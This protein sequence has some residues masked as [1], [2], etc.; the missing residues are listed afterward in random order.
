MGFRFTT[1]L[2]M[3][4]VAGLCLSLPPAGQ[5]AGVDDLLGCSSLQKAIE[6]EDGSVV[7]IGSTDGCYSNLA[8]RGWTFLVA[9]SSDGKLLPSFGSGGLVRLP[10]GTDSLLLGRPNG[11]VIVLSGGALVSYGANG[12]PDASFGNNGQLTRDAIRRV[13][14]GSDHKLYVLWGNTE[15]ILER[16]NL[17]GTV[18]DGF[19]N[20]G[21]LRI[22]RPFDSGVGPAIDVEGR[23]Y[24]IDGHTAIRLLPDGSP[25]PD[26]GSG[27]N[28]EVELDV[29]PAPP[30][31]YFPNLVRKIELDRDGNF[32]V[33][34]TGSYDLYSKPSFAAGLDPSGNPLP[35]LPYLMSTMDIGSVSLYNG[36][37][38]YAQAPD[39][40]DHTEAF[41][42]W[43]TGWYGTVNSF[44]TDS[45]SPAYAEETT[46]L[47]DGSLLAVGTTTGQICPPSGKCRSRGTRIALL[48]VSASGTIVPSFGEGG[49]VVIPGNECRW[50][51]V[52]GSGDW[53]SCR[54]RPPR[55]RGSVELFGAR[56]ARPWLRVEAGLGPVS[57]KLGQGRQTLAFTLP[58]WLKVKKAKLL[59]KSVATS[60]PGGKQKVEVRGRNLK[61]TVRQS[62]PIR[63]WVRLR[64][65]ALTVKPKVKRFRGRKLH[66]RATFVPYS[67]SVDAPGKSSTRLP[68][69]IV[70]RGGR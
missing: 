27:G 56:S 57:E 39:R 48:K 38:A 12:R 30:G 13:V 20:G 55:I 23:I 33:F 19:G 3:I 40:W 16:F 6:R 43:A 10:D 53:D 44:F 42:V 14:I 2:L 15:R 66:L 28:G 24:L 49:R 45:Q 18:D 65:G 31:F 46:P 50:G 9:L 41:S 61:V 26:F 8:P 54:L 59:R 69:R 47:A 1:G 17:D 11:E 37:V 70:A 35:G 52:D 34:G 7:A 21:R 22:E 67:G 4:A 36:G 51:K 60:M 25:D 29:N 58:G 32:Y 63:V 62:R 64:P 68:F 5:A